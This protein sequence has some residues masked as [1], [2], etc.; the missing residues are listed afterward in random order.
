MET[1]DDDSLYSV[2]VR[3]FFQ[4]RSFFP[5]SDFFLPYLFLSCVPASFLLALLF[6]VSYLY[7]SSSKLAVCIFVT[8]FLLSSFLPKFFLI[9]S[10]SFF[11][12]FFG[13]VSSA[14][15]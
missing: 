4:T 7:F 12:Q 11:S 14:N 1:R 9:S 5:V 6:H 3:H 2:I 8:L 13:R 15:F 10:P